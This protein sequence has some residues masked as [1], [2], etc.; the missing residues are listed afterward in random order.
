MTAPPS[1]ETIRLT[2]GVVEL[3]VPAAF[4][5]RVMHYGFVDGPNVF[6]DAAAAQRET[7]HGMWRAYGG[8]RLWAAPE[9]FPETYTVDD[10]P[11]AIEHTGLRLLAR[12][13][14]DPQ[15]GLVAGIELQLDPDGTGVRVTHELANEGRSPQRLAAWGLTVVAAGGTALIPNPEFR[16]Q[17]EA[18]LPARAMVLWRY[19]DL[20]DPRFVFGPSFV[21]LRCDPERPTPNKIGVAC[22]RGW[23]AYLTG[24]TAFVVRTAYDAAADYPDR[25]CSVEVYTEGGFCE[26][27][28]LAPLTTLAP[29]EVTRHVERWSLAGGLDAPD[30]AS[31]ADALG[32]HVAQ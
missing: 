13:A 22:E 14:R 3:R 12:R 32:K 5:P 30:D 25:D 7:P 4:G 8:H 1:P 2:N 10:R 26:V 21:R 18:L 15:T 20:S 16:P 9:R 29:G 24:G 17:R 28:T 6:G 31:L 19:T 27:E 23:F 11:P